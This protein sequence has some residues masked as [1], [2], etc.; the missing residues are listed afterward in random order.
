MADNNGNFVIRTVFWTL[1]IGS[2]G[3]TSALYF[4]GTSLVRANDDKR[5]NEDKQICMTMKAEDDTLRKDFLVAIKDIYSE[6]KKDMKEV[7]SKLEIL[8][9]SVVEL[10]SEIKKR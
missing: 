6:N 9:N 10:K 8:S 2:F 7:Q 1:I 3:W 5:A 4:F